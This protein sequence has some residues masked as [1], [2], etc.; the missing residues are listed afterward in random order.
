[1]AN[2]SNALKGG[3]SPM[4]TNRWI[5]ATFVLLALGA[6]TACAPRCQTH[7]ETAACGFPVLTG[8]YLGQLPPGREAVLFAP[9]IVST[10][11]SELNSVFTPDGTEFYYAVD[12]GLDWVIMVSHQRDGVWSEP[13]VASFTRGHSGVDLCLSAD[14]QRLLFCSD[15]PR[16]GDSGARGNFDIWYVDRTADGGWSEP[17]NLEEV[18]SDAAEFYPWLTADNTLYFQSRRQGGIGGGDLY[19]ARLVD[20][21][22]AEAE[23]L[24][25]VINTP[26]NEGDVFIAA[27]ES[28]LIFNSR[29]RDRGPGDG[30]LFIS[31]RGPDDSWSPPTNLGRVMNADRSDFCPVV[32]PDGRYFFF[33]SARPRLTDASGNITWKSLHDAQ[34]QPEN[35]STDVYWVD[36]SFIDD[37]RPE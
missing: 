4:T 32:S 22:Y 6:G 21:R 18:N 30:S 23:N 14:G 34:S 11:L 26:G 29:G 31:F 20:G 1:M 3:T 37:L 8:P 17:V 28:Y 25:P 9:G 13:E 15:R 7:D 19:R 2:G 5:V 24:G 10:G 35:G 33:S 36:A 12:I 16:S 27:D